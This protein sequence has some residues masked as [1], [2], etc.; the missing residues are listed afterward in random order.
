MCAIIRQYLIFQT[1]YEKINFSY[2]GKY[3]IKTAC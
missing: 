2:S 1:D 3:G